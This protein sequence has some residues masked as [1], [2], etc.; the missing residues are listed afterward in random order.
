M[1]DKLNTQEGNIAYELFCQQ[2]KLDQSKIL[3]VYEFMTFI[4]L[5]VKTIR[6]SMQI[7]DAEALPVSRQTKRQIQMLNSEY[8]PILLKAMIA[9]R[10]A[11]YRWPFFKLK[12][13][14][15]V[16]LGM[17]FSIYYELVTLYRQF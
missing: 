7:P 5:G 12:K 16:F 15:Y 9:K 11:S 1:T 10:Y 13:Y 14:S 4:N 2:R 8:G 6:L 3:T 17:V